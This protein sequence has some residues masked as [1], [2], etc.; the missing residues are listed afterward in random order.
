MMARTLGHICVPAARFFLAQGDTFAYNFVQQHPP[1]LSTMRTRGVTF[2]GF[3]H[4][5]K[6]ARNPAILQTSASSGGFF[7]PTVRAAGAYR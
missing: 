5:R 7:M 4:A 6:P 1:R 3:A 2:L